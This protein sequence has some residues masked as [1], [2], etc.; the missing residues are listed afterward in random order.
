[1]S[2]VGPR[3]LTIL[4]D[5]FA[6]SGANRGFIE[7]T[8]PPDDPIVLT[9]R[10]AYPILP[11][12]S[13]RRD[14]SRTLLRRRN[15]FSAGVLVIGLFPEALAACIAAEQKSRGSARVYRWARRGR[16]TGRYGAAL[17]R[18]R[19]PD[20]PAGHRNGCHRPDHAGFA[21]GQLLTHSISKTSSV[22]CPPR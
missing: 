20:P 21:A 22:G 19:R 5:L 18:Q 15:L 8:G 6:G 7:G 17:G 2:D 11:S 4:A 13:L 9:S 16:R 14:W 10:M 12:G 1:M 3:A